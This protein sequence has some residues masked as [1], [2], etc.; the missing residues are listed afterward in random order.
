MVIPILAGMT[1]FISTF[2]VS[3]LLL[4]RKGRMHVAIK[5]ELEKTQATKKGTPTVGGLAFCFGTIL[6]IAIM[7]WKAGD[8]SSLVLAITL[9]LFALIG[10]LD[11]IAK[12]HSKI[13]DG[14][15]SRSKIVLQVICSLV[16]LVFMQWFGLLSSEVT[17]PVLGIHLDC[18]FLY[19]V[20][21]F[22]YIL[23]FSNAVNIADGLDGLAAGSSLPL[24]FFVFAIAVWKV[25]FNGVVLFLAA[26]I[27]SILAFLW[28]NVKPARYFMGDC[29]S[30]AIGSVIAVSAL[31]SKVEIFI[32]LA[33][34]VF[35]LEFSTSLIQII[36][37]RRLKRKVFPIAPLHHVFELKGIGETTIVGRYCIAS[38]LCTVLAFLLFLLTYR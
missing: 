17:L 16:V 13:G 2:V 3:Q 18:K 29:G 25:S 14:L 12:T 20:G 38:W 37:I 7:Q 15:T 33:S 8:A 23:Y 24:V 6:P 27:G 31:L 34:G 4:S 35:L 19:P 10:F 26:F 1:G 36:S 21:A 9:L 22:F 28:Y 30:Q 5:P 11:D 32:L